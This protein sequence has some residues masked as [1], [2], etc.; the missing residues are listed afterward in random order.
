[1]K[2]I[3]T[4]VAVKYCKHKNR[5][6]P[7]KRRQEDITRDYSISVYKAELANKQLTINGYMTIISK[8]FNYTDARKI[9]SKFSI[10]DMIKTKSQLDIDAKK[11]GLDL[12][13]KLQLNNYSAKELL[14]G[15]NKKDTKDLL[16]HMIDNYRKKAIVLFDPNN[17]Q[18]ATRYA[19][20]LKRN[21]EDQYYEPVLTTSDGNCFYNAKSLELYGHENNSKR[22]R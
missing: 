19:G 10:H 15:F 5:N 1:M 7:Q 20:F 6:E 11:S 16:N 22:L 9:P 21:N 17:N 14:I 18:I 8:L 4:S 13:D 3:E 2:E 12:Y